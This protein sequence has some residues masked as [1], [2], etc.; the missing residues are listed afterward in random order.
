M[1]AQ[2]LTLDNVDGSDVVY[3]LVSQGE[4][5]T[6]R[7]DAATDLAYPKKLVIKHQETGPQTSRV[8]RHLVQFT[9]SVAGS[10]GP[11]T[12]GVNMTVSVPRDAAATTTLVKNLCANLADFLLD[13]GMASM[14][15]TTNIT[16][17]L[18][19]GS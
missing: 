14:A 10:D 4:T 7:L 1:L 18:R 3:N 11:V 5:G 12:I 6:T 2:T 16:E 8:D 15:T 9:H 17:I 19:G 13:G